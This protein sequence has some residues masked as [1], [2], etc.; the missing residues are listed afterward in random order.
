MLPERETVPRQAMRRQLEDMVVLTAKQFEEDG[1]E[2]AASKITK[3]LDY[4][5]DQSALLLSLTSESICPLKSRTCSTL[6][7]K[8]DAPCRSQTHWKVEHVLLG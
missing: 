7:P 6:S 5:V 2:A 1:L 8:I 4:D 3:L